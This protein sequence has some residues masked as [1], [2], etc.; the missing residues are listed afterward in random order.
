[1]TNG[2]TVKVGKM[3]RESRRLHLHE[4]QG[5]ATVLGVWDVS[6]GRVAARMESA[7]LGSWRSAGIPPGATRDDMPYNGY[8]ETA[9][10]ALV[11]LASTITL[12]ESLLHVE[13]AA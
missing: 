4:L 7:V 2:T 11:D 1:V 9:P 12:I 8:T 6:S 13:V 10:L 5:F 3:G